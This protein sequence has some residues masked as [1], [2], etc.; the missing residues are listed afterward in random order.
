MGNF[1][2]ILRK[3][4]NIFAVCGNSFNKISNLIF[5]KCWKT[6]KTLLIFREFLQ[7]SYK[8]LENFEVHFEI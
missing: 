4:G 2:M 5:G 1:E 6:L 3:I 8:L 7:Y